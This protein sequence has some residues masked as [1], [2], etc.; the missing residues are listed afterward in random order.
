[1]DTFSVGDCVEAILDEDGVGPYLKNS[2]GARVGCKYY[3]IKVILHSG[4]GK[5]FYYIS[6]EPGGERMS[7]GVI[8]ESNIRHYIE[9][10]YIMEYKMDGKKVM[11]KKEKI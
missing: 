9:K 11:N 7:N 3:I 1:M 8:L 2:C 10:K 6:K 4:S 5:F